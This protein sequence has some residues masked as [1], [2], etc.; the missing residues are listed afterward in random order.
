MEAHLKNI[1]RYA[2]FSYT[3]L[4]DERLYGY[5]H[6]LTERM[7]LVHLPALI[8]EIGTFP[9]SE[10]L[11]RIP[12]IAYDEELPLVRTLW[13]TMFR[14]APELQ[15]AF[16][17]PDLRIIRDLVINGHGWRVLPDYH[18]ADAFAQGQLVT[19]TRI[20]SAPTNNLYLVWDKRKL[21]HGQNA[22]MREIVL[23]NFP[24]HC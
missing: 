19:P 16:T 11:M 4:S 17:I 18:C 5:A 13:S 6:L 21:N 20:G 14:L 24:I 3:T 22:R 8:K 7:L 9:D 23:G 10:V 12:L 2:C 15:A 1:L